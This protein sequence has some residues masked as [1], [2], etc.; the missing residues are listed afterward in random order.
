MA[1]KKTKS[2]KSPSGRDVTKRY[3]RAQYVAKLRRF[4][5]AIE[6]GRPFVIQVAGERI[7]VP[8][9]ATFNIEHE[10]GRDAEEIEF[11]MTWTPG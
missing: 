1:A 11:Q 7:H 9:R 3:A 2:S 6:T 10:R 4:A 5:D 8:A